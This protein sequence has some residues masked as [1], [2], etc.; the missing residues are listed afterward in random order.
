MPPR[1]LKETTVGSPNFR[2]AAALVVALMIFVL[3]IMLI[4]IR[5][6]KFQEE[7]C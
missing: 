2:V 1:F 7:T 4:T 6:C 5:R 3:P